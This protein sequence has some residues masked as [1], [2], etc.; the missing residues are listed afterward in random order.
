MLPETMCVFQ[1]KNIYFFWI[2][3]ISILCFLK[4]SYVDALNIFISVF[5]SVVKKETMYFIFQK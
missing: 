2:L 1:C 5:V 4:D 3:Q